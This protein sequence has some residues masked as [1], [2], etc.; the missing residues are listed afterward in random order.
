MA[1]VAEQLVGR[2]A[3]LDAFDQALTE[4]EQGGGCAR[5]RRRAGDRQDR[6]LA[7]LA[8]AR[9][10]ARYL[11]LSGS[12]SELEQDLPFWV[13]VDALDEYIRGLEPERLQS[14]SDDVRT[15]CRPSSPRSPGSTRV[16]RPPPSTSATA[17]TAPSASCWSSSRDPAARARARRRHWADPASVELLGALL[18][19]PPAAPVLLA[20]GGAPPTAVRTAG[21]RTRARAS[22]RRART[23]SS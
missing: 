15:E 23:R 19:R 14:S 1:Q 16:A 6:L 9:T 8:A 21:G 5:A 17:A 10:R 18:Q 7:E 2:T 11:V 12:A 22:D 13:F 20:L 3:E 4:L